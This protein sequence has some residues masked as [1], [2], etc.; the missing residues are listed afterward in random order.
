MSQSLGA[1][2]TPSG[3]G[4]EELKKQNDCVDRVMFMTSLTWEGA[5]PDTWNHG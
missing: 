3:T 4:S 5:N 1:G 2:G